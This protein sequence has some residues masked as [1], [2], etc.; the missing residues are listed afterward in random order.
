[1]HQ[2]SEKVNGIIIAVNFKLLRK[3]M[4]SLSN[5]NFLRVIDVKKN[6]DNNANDKNLLDTGKSFT[7]DQTDNIENKFDNML[8]NKEFIAGLGELGEQKN[9]KLKKKL[10]TENSEVLAV[11]TSLKVTENQIESQLEPATIEKQKDKSISLNL[12]KN[13]FSNSNSS[14]KNEQI[15]TNVIEKI[16]KQHGTKNDLENDILNKSQAVIESMNKNKLDP[17]KKIIINASKKSKIKSFFQNYFNYTLKKY[18][19]KNINLKK[20]HLTSFIN[21][22]SKNYKDG[23]TFITNNST[24]FDH[25]NKAI[26][27]PKNDINFENTIKDQT[28]FNESNLKTSIDKNETS[29]KD[30]SFDNFDRLKN[31]LDIRSNDIKQRFSQ[32]LENNIRMNNNKFEIQLRPEN[33]GKIYITLEITGQNVDININSDNINTIQSLTENNSSLQKML[34]NHGMNLN[35]FNFNGNNSKGSGKD[36]KKSEALKDDNLKVNTKNNNEEESF[37]SKNLVYVKA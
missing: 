4:E 7:V 2:Y 10:K 23:I 12:L 25:K 35:N 1:M 28:S 14:N 6:K 9:K 31:I 3:V 8:S 20:S 33:L 26:T 21:Y 17:D 32:I 18:S 36:T 27:K 16:S 13:N 37:V 29:M 19:K 5:F 24:K 30:T 15:Q 34:Q 22:E 11:E